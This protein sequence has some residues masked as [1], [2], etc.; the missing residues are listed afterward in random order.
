MSIIDTHSHLFTEEFD[1]DLPEVIRRAQ[2]AGVSRIYMPNIDS[3]TIESLLRVCKEYPGYCFPMLGLHPTSVSDD[4]RGH[5]DAM[6]RLLDNPDYSF[7]A[8]GEVGLDLYWDKTYQKEQEDAFR[9]Q[10]EWAI[11][12]Q[13]P[14]IVHCRSAFKEMYELLLPYKGRQLKGIFHSFSGTVE[15]AEKL[16]SFDGFMLGINGTLT[17]KKS[18]LPHVLSQLPLE[19]IVV[20]TDSPYLTPVPYRGKR[21]ESAYIKYTLQR[22]AEVYGKRVEEMAEI[23]QNNALKLFGMG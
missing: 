16:L 6:K 8:I 13:L 2:E 14:L 11:A 17:F 12:Y 20:E 18:E 7:V 1:R 22:L 5:L 3:S 21:N 10:I 9:I 23:T 19:R 4:Y 15:E